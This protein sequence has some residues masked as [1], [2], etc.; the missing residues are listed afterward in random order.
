MVTG[1]IPDAIK[2]PDTV[3]NNLYNKECWCYGHSKEHL[4]QQLIADFI[5]D[6]VRS[7]WHCVKRIRV[8]SYLYCGIFYAVWYTK[9]YM[10]QKGTNS[11][12]IPEIMVLLKTD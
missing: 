1:V 6:T 7:N 9:K 3:K 8:F 4:K 11:T 2:L 10:I 5:A 12:I